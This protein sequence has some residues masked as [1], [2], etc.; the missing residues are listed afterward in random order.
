LA[1]NI[2]VAVSSDCD[3]RRCRGNVSNTRRRDDTEPDSAS[4]PTHQ[5]RL[6]SQKEAREVR[7]DCS[8]GSDAGGINQNIRHCSPVVN[9]LGQPQP[10]SREFQ[11]RNLAAGIE[12]SGRRLPCTRVL[13]LGIHP[14]TWHPLAS[15][16]TNPLSRYE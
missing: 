5:I 4:F 8:V 12:N 7:S 6:R 3:G 14:P 10:A 13:I 1:T 16:R 15:P 2:L 9:L 11:K